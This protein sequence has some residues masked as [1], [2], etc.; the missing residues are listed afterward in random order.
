MLRTVVFFVGRCLS[1][2]GIILGFVGF[3]IMFEPL[4]AMAYIP[5]SIVY[6]IRIL[7]LAVPAILLGRLFQW[8]VHDDWFW[9]WGA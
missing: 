2:L 6:G 4:I 7:I 1:L 3:L 9:K 8:L 5:I